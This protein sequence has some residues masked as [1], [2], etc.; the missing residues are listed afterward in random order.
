MADLVV[1]MASTGRHKE[2][3]RGGSNLS[4]GTLA[5]RLL[6]INPLYLLLRATGRIVVEQLVAT[7]FGNGFPSSPSSFC[8]VC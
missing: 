1:L 7:A 5:K 4:V 8:F 3:V 6:G 2:E